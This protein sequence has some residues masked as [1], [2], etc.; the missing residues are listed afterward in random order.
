MSL[1]AGRAERRLGTTGLLADLARA[2]RND[3][4]TSHQAAERVRA[5]GAL[6]ESQLIVRDAVRRWPGKTAVELGRLLDGTPCREIP[7]EDH[8]WRIEASRRLAE[9]DPVHV[10]RGESRSCSIAGT[11]QAT[12]WPAT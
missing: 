3:P 12:W 11:Q 10:R 1:D 7:R 8:W 5:S 9:L 4:S 2:R 6:R